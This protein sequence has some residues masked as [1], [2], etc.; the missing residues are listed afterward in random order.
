MLDRIEIVGGGVARLDIEVH[1]LD[2][3]VTVGGEMK[4]II[5]M[6]TDSH[7]LWSVGAF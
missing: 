1:M 2:I 4:L 5:E 6:K 3:V 7:A